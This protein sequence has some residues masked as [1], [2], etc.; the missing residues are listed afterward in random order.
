VDS[1]P[2]GCI[3]LVQIKLEYIIAQNEG[4]RAER[5]C[6]E[7][8]NR[9]TTTEEKVKL[10]DCFASYILY[11]SASSFLN[12]AERQARQALEL[13]PGTLTLKGS[14]GGILVEQGRFA[15]AEPLLRE[16]L[17]RSPALHDQGISS[18]YLGVAKLSAGDRI[19]A[20]RLIKRGM[21]L[22]P[23]PWLLAKAKGKLTELGA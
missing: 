5:V 22:H 1:N 13:A 23:E 11:K 16:C 18:F 14:L 19:E 20:K 8:F 17:E 2:A 4:E 12:N 15:E 6:L 7:W 10:L 3:S 9:L 21:V